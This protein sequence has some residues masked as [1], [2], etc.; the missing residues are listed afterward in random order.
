MNSQLRRFDIGR[1]QCAVIRD[2]GHMGTANFLFT[3][4]QAEDLNRVL[5]EHQLEPQQLP[6]SWN[7]LFVDTGDKKI[8]VDTGIGS[9]IGLT[10]GQLLE[11]LLSLGV[12]ADQIDVV[13]LSHCHPDHI[14]GCTDSSG[15]LI[16]SNARFVLSQA[17]WEFW[18]SERNLKKLDDF[19]GQFARKNLPPLRKRV[20]LITV[21]SEISPGISAVMAPGHT[22]GHI[23]LKISSED[24]NLF[25]LADT[26]LHPIHIER[27]DWIAAVDM[28]PEQVVATRRRL[29]ERLAAE[30]ARALI[31]H[32]DFPA[33]G[34]VDS[35]GKQWRWRPLA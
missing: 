25:Y 12:R 9:G 34:T 21:D 29:L 20:D 19:F 7:C 17:E 3:N 30:N 18:T 6:T 15:R 11:H 10:E 24:D 33:L 8:L 26:V 22:P 13:V 2:G 32:F 14:G 35:S 16:Y 1:F 5:Q 31:Y 28:D 23:A 4:A 27:P